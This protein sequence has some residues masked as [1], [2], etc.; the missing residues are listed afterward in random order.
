MTKP[1]PENVESCDMARV[2]LPVASWRNSRG[3]I[4]ELL[5]LIFNLLDNSGECGR[6]VVRRGLQEE[7]V[8]IKSKGSSEK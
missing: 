3:L 7:V 6:H 2:A 8:F 4:R 1:Y 5:L